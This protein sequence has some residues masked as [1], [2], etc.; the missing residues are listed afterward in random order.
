M[1]KENRKHKDSVFV[2]LFYNYKNAK[3]YQLM[4]YN[5]LMDTDYKQGEVEIEDVRLEDV[6]YKNFQNDV[7]MGINKKY[8]VFGEHQ[9]AINLNMPLRHLLYLGRTYEKMISTRQRHLRRKIRIPYPEFYVFYNGTEEYPV[10]SELRLS[11]SFAE[12]PKGEEPSVELVVKVININLDKQHPILE[13]CPVLKEYMQFVEKVRRAAEEGE[14]EPI[15]CAVQS[16]IRQGILKEYLTDRGSEV[17]NMLIGE[18]SYEED[19]E[20]QREEAYEEGLVRGKEEGLVQGYT[21]GYAQSILNLLEMHGDVPEGIRQ[22]IQQEQENKQ[23]MVWLQLA[24]KVNSVEEFA[25]KM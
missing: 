6:L 1:H 5:A 15:K 8:L 12:Y 20:V 13:K 3:E 9:S 17:S 23:L 2:D 21:K 24:A 22:R 19:I 7:A 25:E 11:D 10:E 4:L 16:C 14:E 18:Y